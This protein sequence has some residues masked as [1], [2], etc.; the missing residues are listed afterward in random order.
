MPQLPRPT[1]TK[2]DSS[3]SGADIDMTTSSSSHHLRRD[4]QARMPSASRQ[5]DKLAS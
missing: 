5:S 2:D 1:S 4:K 3:I